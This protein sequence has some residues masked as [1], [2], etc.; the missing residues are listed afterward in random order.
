MRFLRYMPGGPGLLARSRTSPRTFGDVYEEMAENVLRYFWRETRDEQVALDLTAETFAVAFEKRK[1]FR[2]ASDGQASAWV[3]KIARSQLTH[4][5]R[6][7]K[8]ELAALRRVGFERPIA[9]DDEFLEIELLAAEKDINACL[10]AAI[11]KLSADQQ[12]VIRLR[13]SHALS[14]PEI[15][16]ELGV[17]DDVARTRMSR[18]LRALRDNEHIHD[19]RALRRT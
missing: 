15:A 9:T 13:F 19:I 5:V 4:F 3:W 18:A 10:H 16:Q 8:V 1:D 2:G 14:Y 6:H 17:S 11:G 7:K 12:E